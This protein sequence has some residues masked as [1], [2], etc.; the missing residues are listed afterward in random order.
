IAQRVATVGAPGD[1]VTAQWAAQDAANNQSSLAANQQSSLDANTQH[2]TAARVKNVSDANGAGFAGA[3][4]RSSIAQGL[5]D[6]LTKLNTQKS[7]EDASRR[8]QALQLA[9]TM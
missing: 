5:A 7:T 8:Q 1:S 6:N 2:E 4:Q 9:I 3:E